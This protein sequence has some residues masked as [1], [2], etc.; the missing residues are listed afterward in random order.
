MTA[1]VAT[2]EKMLVYDLLS[3]VLLFSPLLLS[4]GL[5][6]SPDTDQV[7]LFFFSFRFFL[8][9]PGRRLRKRRP[10]LYCTRKKKNLKRTQDKLCTFEGASTSL[11]ASLQPF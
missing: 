11:Y 10:A 8:T 4:S 2:V 7:G 1:A 5:Y 3:A 6:G 9:E